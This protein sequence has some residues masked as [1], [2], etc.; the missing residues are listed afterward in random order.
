MTITN[1]ITGALRSLK[2]EKRPL[3]N[4]S[5]ATIGNYA[6]VAQDESLKAN[7]KA[8]HG[9][10]PITTPPTD[11]NIDLV[12]TSR[13][14]S[15]FPFANAAG[16]ILKNSAGQVSTPFVIDPVLS[17]GDLNIEY[18]DKL[19]KS[20]SLEHLFVNG[21]I[22]P[23][24]YDTDTNSAELLAPFRNHFTLNSKGLLIDAKNGGLRRD[25]SRGLDDQYFNK[26]HGI[27]VFGVDREGN[28]IADGNNEPIGDQWKFFRDYYMLHQPIDDS[29]A[30][31]ISP[32]NE[33]FGLDNVTNNEPSTRMRFTNQVVARDVVH[34][35]P[36]RGSRSNY[37]RAW[38]RP[39]ESSITP[40]ILTKLKYR[41][42][43]NLN[44]N[45]SKN[46]WNLF[47]PQIRP[48]VIRNSLKISIK[49]VLYTSTNTSDP[50]NGKYYLEF[51][52]YP[53]ITLWNPFNVAIEFNNSLSDN[54]L[55]NGY[56]MY[57][58]QTGTMNVEI[59]VRDVGGNTRIEEYALGSISPNVA[60][61]NEDSLSAEL[62]RTS[63]PPG[64]VMICGLT[65]NYYA[66]RNGSNPQY[67]T[68][69]NGGQSSGFIEL[70][71][72]T[73]INENYHVTYRDNDARDNQGRIIWDRI[74]YNEDDILTLYPLRSGTG[75]DTYRW[76]G[77]IDSKKNTGAGIRFD[78]FYQGENANIDGTSSTTT[79]L[80]TVL[81]LVN[82]D[83]F[84]TN[85]IDI[86]ARTIG[87][88]PGNPA[89][90]VFAQMN[91]MGTYPQVVDGSSSGDVNGDV[92]ILYIS[93]LMENVQSDPMSGR[94]SDGFASYGTSLESGQGESK[95]LLYDLP[96]HPI[97]SIG[98]F[99]N[100]VF[101]WNEDTSPRPIGAS[102]PSGTIS[103]L[104]KTFVPVG[105]GSSAHSKGAGCDTSYH[106][107]NSLFDSY[108]LSGISPENRDKDVTFPY[109]RTL[110][111][112]YI[113]QGSPIA[114]T[115]LVY[116]K[117]PTATEIR[118][119]TVSESGIEADA[120]EAAA[121]HLLIDTPFNV[122]STSSIAWQAVLSGFRNQS[123][124][125]INSDK[126]KRYT[127]EGSP[128]I[129]HFIPS[130]EQD[131][132][133]VGHRRLSDEDLRDLSENIVAEIRERK[134]AKSLGSFINR[135]PTGTGRNLEMSRIDEAIINAG[136]NSSSETIANSVQSDVYALDSPGYKPAAH[137]FG[138]ALVEETGAGLPGYF[139]QQDILRPLAPIMTTR[140]DT[141]I[142]RAYG[143]SVDPI[144]QEVT[145]RAWCE[146]TL[147]RTPEYMDK[148]TPAWVY[149]PTDSLN[150]KFG[151]R[152]SVI[153]FRWID[154]QDTNS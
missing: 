41:S 76:L 108:F 99:K 39:Y 18:F 11:P 84:P 129:D 118:E 5:G 46:D 112:P 66:D 69:P 81:N 101:S 153:N 152:F 107:N 83:P 128:Y 88:E 145:G 146:I 75:N 98:D 49:P 103:D 25:L 106:Y 1:P 64:A 10:Y 136:I 27:P 68:S 119:K 139:K 12:E 42:D 154:N 24:A 140:G 92:R 144:T 123:I 72:G 62:G 4:N 97:V 73:Q 85:A 45:I 79:T 70:G 3:V 63:M 149:P 110:T 124:E 7:L 31:N 143:E 71:L 19:K 53:T 17:S 59:G 55:A 61:I 130:G 28:V 2:A 91:L 14:L 86:R 29:L 21:I 8:E 135:D 43:N 23:S 105:R 132:L 40:D 33:L 26:L 50:N 35:F 120:F 115:Q 134:V 36:Q 20:S 47:T 90:P 126:S 148:E 74:Y 147:Q 122:N 22:E 6:W 44:F 93:N 34:L 95:I 38:A 51:R 54:P 138:N 113:A 89:F 15:V 60:L 111:D 104:E 9:N 48:V 142:I 141:F 57:L 37:A 133:Y 77:Q 13:R 78:S 125:G 80:G 117:E 67:S 16:V 116:Y 137:M 100:L 127:G 82:Q 109:G 114:N 65:Q 94:R 131:E 58:F 102:W 151:R 87:N 150:S 30:K 121:S 96:R 32:V 52:V 56:Q